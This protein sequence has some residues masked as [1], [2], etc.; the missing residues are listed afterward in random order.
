MLL[1]AGIV[2]AAERPSAVP[3]PVGDLVVED[4]SRASALHREPVAAG[5]QFTIEYVHSSERVPVTGTFRV[6]EDGCLAVVETAFAGFGPGLPEL[7]PGDDWRIEG[8][9]IVHRPPE[10]K[11]D[12]LR[13]RVAPVAAQRLR[14]PA[15]V[16]LHLAGLVSAGSAV[17]IAV[18]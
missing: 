14:T 8:G 12:E 7:R 6:E 3:R 18:R 5:A 16:V 1:A 2:G 11:I 13:L 9:M 15:G 10:L 17:R 4:V